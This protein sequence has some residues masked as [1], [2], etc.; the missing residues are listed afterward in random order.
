MRSSKEEIRQKVADYLNKK[1]SE[2]VHNKGRFASQKEFAKYLGVTSWNLNNWM[3]GERE[4]TGKNIHRLAAKLGPEVYDVLEEPRRM[5]E[6]PE[7]VALAKRWFSATKSRR[8][9]AMKILL[10]DEEESSQ[11]EE[12]EQLELQKT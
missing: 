9:A 3:L 4:P 6:D 8:D 10:G 2:Y 1:F 11:E 7:F 5:P 12:A